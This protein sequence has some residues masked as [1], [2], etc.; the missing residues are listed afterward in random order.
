M[1][2]L[3]LNQDQSLSIETPSGDVEVCVLEVHPET[4]EATIEVLVPGEWQSGTTPTT[5][6]KVHDEFVVGTPDGEIRQK[7]LRFRP[8]PDG[9]GGSVAL[10]VDAPR[11][12][13]ILR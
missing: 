7:V 13:P 3:R 6:Y 10:G 1:L 2:D 5:T 12:W 8:R 11:S 4:S 9:S